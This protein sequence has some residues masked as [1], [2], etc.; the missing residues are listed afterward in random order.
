LHPDIK[1]EQLDSAHWRLKGASRP[2]WLQAFE[3]HDSGITAGQVEP[4][5]QGWYSQEFGKRVPNSVISFQKAGRLPLLFGY[6]VSCA[7]HL[8]I[9][10]R[11]SGSEGQ[12][13]ALQDE[14]II[15][16]LLIKRENVRYIS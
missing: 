14:K 12:E 4:I 8:P 11:Y 10:C 16:R 2:L 13:I 7:E 3:H 5:I 9:G 15:H 6:V 1:P